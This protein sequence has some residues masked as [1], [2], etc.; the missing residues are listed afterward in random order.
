MNCELCSSSEGLTSFELENNNVANHDRV[1]TVCSKCQS[2]LVENNFSDTNH[3]RAL[4][5]AIWS[6]RSSVKVLSYRILY[7]LQAETWAQNLLEQIYLEEEEL[8]W[9]KTGLSAPAGSESPKPTKDS[10]GT[11]LAEGDSVTLIKDLDVKGAGFTAKRGT[12]VK[13]IR[14][15]E[16]PEHIEGRVNGITIVLI[17]D[18]LK[19]A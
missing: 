8:V 15:T 2:S 11:I 3:W 4:N 5:E 13:N 12:L 6:E 16:N 19:K 14:L 9:A 7:H 18:F 10:N 1:F 17:A